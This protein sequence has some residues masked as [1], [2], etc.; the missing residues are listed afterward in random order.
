MNLASFLNNEK[1]STAFFYYTHKEVVV[2]VVAVVFVAE[3]LTQTNMLMRVPPTMHVNTWNPDRRTNKVKYSTSSCSP[4]G[5]H[6]Q[7]F[8]LDIISFTVCCVQRRFLTMS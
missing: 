3:T 8:L 7:T 2:V 1:N 4:F 6:T 5:H